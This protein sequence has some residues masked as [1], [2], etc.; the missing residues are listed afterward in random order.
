DGTLI[1]LH[2]EE[3][4]SRIFHRELAARGIRWRSRLQLDSFDL[5]LTYVAHGF[6]TA[7]SLL[8]P[9]VP[10]GIRLLPLTAFP[11]VRICAVWKGRPAPATA[12]LIDELR[13]AGR[14]L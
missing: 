7:L 14:K 9:A 12:A 4:V 8:H 5:L 2:S 13:A 1:D 6:G 10:G 11:R 3:P